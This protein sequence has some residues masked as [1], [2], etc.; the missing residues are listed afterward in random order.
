MADEFGFHDNPH[1]QEDHSC[2]VIH[3][4]ETVYSFQF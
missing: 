1:T 4:L 2:M 3:S